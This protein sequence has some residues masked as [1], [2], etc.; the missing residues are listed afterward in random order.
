MIGTGTVPNWK[1][2]NRRLNFE[3]QSDKRF[4]GIKVMKSRHTKFEKKKTD[5]RV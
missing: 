5:E 1:R 2:K 4:N 3:E